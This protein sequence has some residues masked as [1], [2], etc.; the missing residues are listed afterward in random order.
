MTIEQLKQY[1]EGLAT[2]NVDI[3]SFVWGDAFEQLQNILLNLNG[4]IMIVDSPD[5]NTQNLN[6]SGRVLSYES[7]LVILKLSKLDDLTRKNADLMATMEIILEV[8]RK[9]ENDYLTE[10]IYKF[11]LK[12][13]IKQTQMDNRIGWR[14]AFTIDFDIDVYPN[15][16]KWQ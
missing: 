9:I 8:V 11:T 7:E 14:F 2:S 3:Q 4:V 1:F 5:F 6:D 15:S 12:S 13:K 10:D 16:E